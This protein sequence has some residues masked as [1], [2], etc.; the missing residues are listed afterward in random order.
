MARKKRK[1]SVDDEQLYQE[2]RRDRRNDRRRRAVPG[3]RIPRKLIAALILFAALIWFLPTI[4]A[5]SPLKQWAINM[6]LADFKGNVEVE[7]ISWGWLTHIRLNRVIARDENNQL[8]LTAGSVYVPKS[9]TSILN[10]TDYGT[11]EIGDPVVY[12]QLRPDGSNLEDAIAD[13]LPTEETDDPGIPMRIQIAQARVEVHD[14]T[15]QHNYLL[16]EVDGEVGLYQKDAPLQAQF[17][18]SI[19]EAG[20]A[21]A[22]DAVVKIDA[23]LDELNFGSGAVELTSKELPIGI[24][25]PVLTRFVEPI[26][27]SGILDGKVIAGWS[28]GGSGITATLTPASLEEVSITAPERIGQDE[29]RLANAWLQGDIAMSPETIRASRFVMQSEIGSFKA[30]GEMNWDQIAV[31]TSQIPANDFSAEG[32]VN[33]APLIAMLPDTLPLQQGMHI[34]SG[35]VQFN[36]ISQAAGTDRRLVI[37]AESAGLTAVRNGQ[38]L[39]WHKPARIVTALR[40]SD[41]R[42]I[43]ESLDCTTNFLTLKGAATR[44]NGEFRVQGDLKSAVAEVARIFDLGGMQ[45]EGKIDGTLAWQFDGNPSENLASRPLR[46]GGRFRIDRPLVNLP[47]RAAWSEEELNVTIQAAGQMRKDAD[48][49]EQIVRLD[50]G[51]LE[52]VNGRQL[53]EANLQKPVERPSLN[54]TWNLDCRMA[55]DL[56]T[57]LAQA[58]AFV[59]LDVAANGNVDVNALVTINPQQI[60]VH[61]SQYELQELDLRGYGLTIQEQQVEGQ[62]QMTWDLET[63]RLQIPDMTVASSAVAARGQQLLLDTST[64][65]GS[66]SGRVAFRAD[67]NRLMA[68]TDPGPGS[69]QWFGNA[70]G[71]ID[72]ATSADAIGGNVAVQFQDLIAARPI[73]STPGMHNVSSGQG[74]WQRVLD[75][76]QVDLGSTLAIS[77]S[78]DQLRFHNL[79]LAASAARI[80]A[81]GTVGDL[82]GN[83]FADV[84]GT[85]EPDWSRLQPLMSSY[86]GDMVTLEQVQGGAF[87]IR[88]PVFAETT[89]PSQSWLNPNL[90]VATQAM[91]SRGSLVGLPMG[92]S[93]M[94][95]NLNGGV[96]AIDAEPIPFS[97]GALLLSPRLDMRTASPTLV[98]PEGTLLDR[99]QLDPRTCKSWLKYVTPVIA[100]VSEAQG[101]LS[102]ATSGAAIPLDQPQSANFTG[103]LVMH[104][105]DIGPGPL[106]QQLIG[107]VDQI[108]S[109]AR[110]NP[111][112]AAAPPQA[113]WLKMPEQEIPFAVQDGRV[114]H[115]D[116]RFQIDDIVVT[117]HGSVGLDES[118]QMVAEV[119]LQDSWLGDSRWLAGLKGKSLRIPVAGTVNRPR[120]DMSILQQLSQQVLQGAASQAIQGEVQGL[121]EQGSERLDGELMKG[122]GRL[123]GGDR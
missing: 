100:E 61:Q 107:L 34:E 104:G 31:V 28:D 29:I 65:A 14:Q 115:K 16:S 113:K 46:V 6:A 95:A 2:N 9:L 99:V 114:Y 74:G 20:Q 97:G 112:T 91:W 102:L 75:E 48:S 86:V 13:M 11:I 78:F 45:L 101:T 57:W 110:G 105:A 84:E 122:L 49:G 59:P 19:N 1:Q 35:T 22:F 81:S 55:G 30:D 82:T 43:L 69:V 58:G 12:L 96:L 26:A 92:G 77:R 40:Q 21:G 93:R 73:P 33:L 4:V 94:T 88:G 15:T 119:T 111:L 27:I 67:I 18:G 90:N 5:N 72:L 37:N 71:S 80:M 23:G 7:S 24:V 47:D 68:W 63:G 38:R 123:L 52:L 3:R 89:S 42:L 121:I 10:A 54:S 53:L 120:L 17:T 32:T 98:V 106:G 87:R 50:T 8:L 85:W 108:K 56:A 83:L 118:L 60:T 117:T 62:A 41:D 36:A 39:N 51:K 25:T 79:Q 103:K 66:L 44:D 70:S 109:I 116:L 64:S 76:K